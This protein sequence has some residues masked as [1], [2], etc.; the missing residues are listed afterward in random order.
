MRYSLVLAL[1]SFLFHGCFEANPFGQTCVSSRGV[2]YFPPAE[3][4]AKY[5]GW[6]KTWSCNSIQRAEDS[7]VENIQKFT[8][9]KINLDLLPLFQV[10]YANSFGW[11]YSDRPDKVVIGSTDYFNRKILVKGD[12]LC[13]YVLTHEFLH[14]VSGGLSFFRCGEA[15][16]DWEE[17][18][19]YAATWAPMQCD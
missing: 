1:L 13:S 2:K 5:M 3:A 8:K 9:T 6:S 10:E 15:H 7:A 16:C 18:G 17:L 19:F 12:M 11:V 14:A 4:L